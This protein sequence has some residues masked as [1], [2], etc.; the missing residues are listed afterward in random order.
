MCVLAVFARIID[1]IVCRSGGKAEVERSVR[2]IVAKDS[3]QV[4][5][6]V[7]TG[8]KIQGR[9]VPGEFPAAALGVY[10]YTVP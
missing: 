3:Q 9:T 2:L 1:D 8:G 4:E 5:R 6:I 10:L 7:H